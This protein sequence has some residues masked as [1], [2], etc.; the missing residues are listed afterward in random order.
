LS[1]FPIQ[2]E[3]GIADQFYLLYYARCV[4]LFFNLLPDEPLQEIQRCVVA[5]FGGQVRQGVDPFAD[6][7]L[8]L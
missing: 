5:D 2:Q 8:M 1:H 7:F 3:K 6:D 4:R